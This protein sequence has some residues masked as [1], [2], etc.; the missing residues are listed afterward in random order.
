MKT[1]L[2]RGMIM[3][4]PGDDRVDQLEWLQTEIAIMKVQMMGQLVGHMALI[5]NLP[6]GQEEIKFL[7]NQLCQEG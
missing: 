7:V 6:Q 1:L 2:A 3:G 4:N 5:Q